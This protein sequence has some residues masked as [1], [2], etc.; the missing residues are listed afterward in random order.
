[1]IKLYLASAIP[2]IK[3]TVQRKYD[4]MS[5]CEPMNFIV[6]GRSKSQYM[7]LALAT[8]DSSV[9]KRS[10]AAVLVSSPANTDA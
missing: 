3:V 2:D 6:G 7:T 4:S 10:S 8:E 5:S 1:M 9:L